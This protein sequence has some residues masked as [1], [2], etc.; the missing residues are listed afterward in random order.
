MS[1]ETMIAF[2]PVPSR[3]LGRSLGINN[4]PPKVCTYS[5]LYCQIGRTAH[6]RIGR[7]LFYGPRR[8]FAA[9]RARVEQLE[10]SGETLD[11][12]T[13]VSDGE[14]TL[15]AALGREIRRLKALGF[16]IAVI[17]NSSL[18]SH[19]DVRQELAAADW[20]SLKVDSVREEVWR[21]LD[22]P[23]PRLR[24]DDILEGIRIFRR[25]FAGKLVT[26]TMLV[27]SVN[28]SEEQ[29]WDLG[30][31]LAQLAPATAYL[32]IPHRPPAETWVQPPTEE[33]LAGAW[34]LV[35]QRVQH[36]ELLTGYE[37]DAFAGEA[38]VEHGLLS[39]AAVH[40]MR[41]DAVAAYVERAG[42]GWEVVAALVAQGRLVEVEHGGHRFYLG[43][44]ARRGSA[45]PGAGSGDGGQEGDPTG[46]QDG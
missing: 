38:D 24:L 13:F 5:C 18:L 8:I 34:A 46:A 42:R 31:Y 7:E 44:F 2:G 14:P 33:S 22:R 23:H 35:S 26:E 29:L 40:P 1:G 41:E 12:L 11:Y 3:R 9:V 19:A 4:I 27:R 37:G 17:S 21:R 15:D 32:S 28:D 39:I 6:M 10:A 30:S 45:P 25:G 16:P 20:V 43:R 36:V